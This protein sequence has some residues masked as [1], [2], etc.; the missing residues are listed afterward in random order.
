MLTI[1]ATATLDAR[2]FFII[3]SRNVKRFTKSQQ[4]Q[5]LL[6]NC[7]YMTSAATNRNLAIPLNSTVISTTLSIICNAMFVAANVSTIPSFYVVINSVIVVNSLRVP[8]EISFAFKENKSTIYR[9]RVKRQ[10]WEQQNALQEKQKR[11]Q[12]RHDREAFTYNVRFLGR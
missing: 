2:T 6:Q 3:K 11:I 9:S 8:I 5:K 1:V 12:A 4:N 7:A 10:E